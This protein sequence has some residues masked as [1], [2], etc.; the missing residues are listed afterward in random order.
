MK[1]TAMISIAA[2]VATALVLTGVYLAWRTYTLSTGMSHSS[3]SGREATE[4]ERLEKLEKRYDKASGYEYMALAYYEDGL[5]GANAVRDAYIP[6]EKNYKQRELRSAYGYAHG[7]GVKQY[8]KKG[9]SAVE[10]NR[11]LQEEVVK[12]LEKEGKEHVLAGAMVTYDNDTVALTNLYYTDE[13]KAMR[14]MFVYT[15]IRDN[16][17]AYLCAE[18]DINPAKFDDQ[19]EGLLKEMDRVFAFNLSQLY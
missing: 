7:V 13:E 18:I 8:M 16:G 10:I 2:V 17:K 19:S 11:E 4:E 9:S 14:T 5:S 6:Y 1:K 12:R 15:D 3:S